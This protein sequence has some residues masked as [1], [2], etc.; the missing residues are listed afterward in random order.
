[1]NFLQGTLDILILTSLSHGPLHGYDVVEWIRTA[2][3]DALQI[4]DGAL[5]TALHRM[6]RRGWLEPEWGVSPKGRRAK[7]Y[8]LTPLGRAEVRAGERRWGRFADAVAKVFA[9]R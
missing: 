3:D 8:H 1:M 6:E 7:Y 2:T 5:Y 4:E 9:A